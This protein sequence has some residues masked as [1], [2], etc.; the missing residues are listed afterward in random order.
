[1]LYCQCVLNGK[2]LVS[3]DSEMARN[4]QKMTKFFNRSIWID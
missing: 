2:K 1:M 4:C 3:E